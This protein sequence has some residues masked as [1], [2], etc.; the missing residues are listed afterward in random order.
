MVSPAPTAPGDASGA[1]PLDGLEDGRYPDDGSPLAGPIRLFSIVG[2]PLAAG[3]ALVLAWQT[4]MPGV[5][6][7]D[8][9]EFQAVPPVLG[10]LHPTGF[11]AYAVLGWLASVL[12]QPL[13]SP[14]FRMNL[15]SAACVAG[16]VGLTAIL[17]RQ[18]TGR[19]LLAIAAGLVLFLTDLAWRISTHADAHSLHLL[20]LAL[21][22]V[23][24][25]GWEARAGG[26]E[27]PR[28]GTDRWLIAAAAVYGVAVANHS[29]ALLVAPGI[30]LFVLAVEPGIL[31]RRGMVARCVAAGLG[32]AVL[33]FLELPLRA[34]PFRAPIVYGHPE[35]LGGFVYVAFGQQFGGELVSGKAALGPRFGGLVDLA[36][37]QLGI[38]AASLPFATLAVVLRRWRYA[39]L[40]V[41]T[42]V[43]TCLFAI[44]YANAD[45]T[46][47]Y[48]GP[49]LILVTWLAILADGLVRWAAQ[50]LDWVRTGPPPTG[51]RSVAIL[52]AVEVAAAV[53]LLAPA[54][55][56]ANTTR[57]A[58]DQSRDTAAEEWLDAVLTTLEPNAVVISWWS[59]STPLWYA[60]DVEGRRPDITIIDDRTILDEDLG[61]V[62]HVIDRYLGQRPVYIIR[63]A[64]ET[65]ALAGRY[66]LMP[67]SDPVDS[68]LAKVVRLR[69]VSP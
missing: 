48:L 34:G 23:L 15:F 18:L 41:P 65:D 29:L 19:P 68:G 63:L 24:L 62:P 61:D 28:P 17:V 14:A 35:T 38:L 49:L 66:L 1:A 4:L 60:R 36:A 39:L 64:A 9:A 47:Y 3:V 40:T 69:T 45:I 20:L 31:G 5:G 7:W 50:A 12:F 55:A 25:V 67:L 52:L 53:V 26:A 54:T 42:L 58:V 46:R 2:P 44:L 10:T 43:I 37:A 59:F 27:G 56:A 51:T 32:V 8:T 30:G 6:F 22:L 13:G 11:P 57:W 33:F 21:M 16:A